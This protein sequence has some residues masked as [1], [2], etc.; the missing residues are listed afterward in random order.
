MSVFYE[1]DPL[2]VFRFRVDFV[3]TNGGKAVALCSG[4]FS[5][6]TGLEATME[7]KTIKE[8]GCNYGPRQRAG[9]VTFGT[10]ILKR[11]ITP[12]RHLWQWFE[13]VNKQ[14]KVA[15]RMNVTVVL[16]DG[17]G[18]PVLKWLLNSAMPVKFK[19]PDLNATASEVGVEELHLVHEGLS[20]EK[21]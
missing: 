19:A 21:A 20:L 15:S 12:A 3:D 16:L 11:G 10:V 17:A 4:L 13:L 14:G 5:E 6:V 1:A 18:K 9:Q 2:H 7:P 8:G